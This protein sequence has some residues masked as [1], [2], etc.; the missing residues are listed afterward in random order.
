MR[1]LQRHRVLADMTIQG[2]LCIRVTLYWLG[3]LLS[4]A[5]T[6][7]WWTALDESPESVVQW[8]QQFWNQYGPVFV[9]SLLVL[10]LALL[11]CLI[12][13][14]RFAGPLMRLRRA[15]KRLANAESVE[16]LHVRRRDLLQ[17]LV[18]D[19]NLAAARLEESNAAIVTTHQTDVAS[20]TCASQ[21]QQMAS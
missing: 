2:G 17:E 12:M 3:C 4:V 10:P 21:Q 7:G 13:S 20:A 1:I 9:I 8:A 19:F 15:M 5:M 11:D 18:N 14:N 16:P 6:L